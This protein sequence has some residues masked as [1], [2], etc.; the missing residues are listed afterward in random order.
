MKTNST[1]IFLP[2]KKVLS[3]VFATNC[4][5]W[6]ASGKARWF[7][8]NVI[9]RQHEGSYFRCDSYERA[10]KC[11]ETLQRVLCFRIKMW[12]KEQRQRC[13]TGEIADQFRLFWFSNSPK[14]VGKFAQIGLLDVVN[15][16]PKGVFTAIREA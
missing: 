13:K 12:R 15:R 6:Y 4:R 1:Y 5:L 7:V 2:K 16:L 9:I 11:G 14:L 3:S 8:Y 10:T